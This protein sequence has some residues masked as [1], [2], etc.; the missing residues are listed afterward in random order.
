MYIHQLDGRGLN[1]DNVGHRV[2]AVFIG[3]V[4]AFAIFGLGYV[5]VMVVGFWRVTRSA[6]GTFMVRL[7]EYSP[8]PWDG[9][10]A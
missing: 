1:P 7:R 9:N 5:I 10:L 8:T 3:V 6:H 2:I 4:L